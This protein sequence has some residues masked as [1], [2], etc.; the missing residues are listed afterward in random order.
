MAP[1]LP[2]QTATLPAP[3][4]ARASAVPALIGRAE[5][6][7]IVAGLAGTAQELTAITADSP[8]LFSLAGAMGAAVMIG[9]GVA[10]A[11][12]GGCA[13]SCCG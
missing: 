2:M 5:D 1:L 6:F 10:L 11:Q 4:L 13:S 3:V 8:R 7:L 12:A 9:L